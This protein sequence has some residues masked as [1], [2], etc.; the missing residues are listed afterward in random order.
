M[1]KIQKKELHR[2]DGFNMTSVFT[3]K[4]KLLPILVYELNLCTYIIM[5]LHL[6]VHKV[7]AFSSMVNT[8]SIM[9]NCLDLEGYI[10]SE[11]SHKRHIVIDK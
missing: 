4:C 5:C 10:L 9:Q 2:V 6:Q 7:H 1:T 3:W 11:D 8:H